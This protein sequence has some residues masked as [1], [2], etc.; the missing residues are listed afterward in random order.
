MYKSLTI[1]LL[2]CT[3]MV[4]C[5][6][7]LRGNVAVSRTFAEI[8]ISGGNILLTEQ[9]SGY[10]RRNGAVV[11]D[12]EIESPTIIFTNAEFER[13]ISTTNEVGIAS[14]YNYRYIV[15][16]NVVDAAGVEIIPNSTI[17][18]FRNLE[19]RSADDLEIAQTE[20][21][22]EAIEQKL[23][24]DELAAAQAECRGIT[25]NQLEIEKEEEF[26]REEM[27]KDISLQIM[28]RLARK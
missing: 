19:H 26:I 17:N 20:C 3:L 4:G 23:P 25:L 6:F 10:L 21:L 15:E 13:T 28:R 2:C 16:F 24:A 7:K 18:Q 11:V 14:G 27:E 22:N 9:L 8:S 12:E 1:L 5:G